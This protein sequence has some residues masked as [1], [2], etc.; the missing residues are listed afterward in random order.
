MSKKHWRYAVYI[1]VEAC[2]VA[3]YMRG[4]PGSRA[5]AQKYGKRLLQLPRGTTDANL[6]VA[7]GVT[8]NR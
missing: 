8:D 4:Y 5:M 3:R 7:S 2:W 1:T 6:L